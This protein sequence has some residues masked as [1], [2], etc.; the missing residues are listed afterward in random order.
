VDTVVVAAV[1]MLVAAV[2]VTW[3]AVVVI[4]V[5]ATV[6]LVAVVVPLTQPQEAILVAGQVL[7]AVPV[8]AA[9]QLLIT[10]YG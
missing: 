6:H 8:L 10:M 5:V 9:V 3:V 7:M 1:V 4:S 2:V